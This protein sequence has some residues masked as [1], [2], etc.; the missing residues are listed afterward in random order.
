MQ[1][2]LLARAFGNVHTIVNRI[3]RSW[4]NETNIDDCAGGPC[5][6]LVD[7][8]AVRIHLQRAIEVSAFL[9]RP[10]SVVFDAAAPEYSLAL[11][12]RG[13]KF[14]PCVVGIDR[15]PGKEVSDLLGAN[16]NIN[17]NRISATNNRLY[18]VQRRGNRDDFDLAAWGIFRLR[19]FTDRKRRR[20]V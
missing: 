9:H 15:A 12:V 17:T 1:S 7:A 5:I 2:D 14:E 20:E 3:S 10:F 16:H 19:L 13:L 18:P 6:A 11:V 4:W 8:V